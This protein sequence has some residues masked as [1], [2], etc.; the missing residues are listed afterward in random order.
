MSDEQR[1]EIEHA[2]GVGAFFYG[3]IP[4]ALGGAA[5]LW[6]AFVSGCLDLEQQRTFASRMDNRVGVVKPLVSPVKLVI[7]QPACPKIDRA[8]I[9]GDT[10]TAY[11]KNTCTR[12][13]SGTPDYAMW[14]INAL[15]PDGTIIWQ[16]Y[17]NQF[18]LPPYGKSVEVSQNVPEDNRITEIDI[19][20]DR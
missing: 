17:T 15:A 9:D 11:V 20:A 5:L 7:L 19:W 2:G 12:P 18:S 6:L 10:V 16:W 4:G 13:N 14:H 8:F 1:V 3:L